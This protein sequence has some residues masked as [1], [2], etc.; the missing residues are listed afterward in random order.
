LKEGDRVLVIACGASAQLRVLRCAAKAGVRVLILGD[1]NA[2]PLKWSTSCDEFILSSKP[3]GDVNITDE[4]LPALADEIN[5]IAKMRDIRMVIPSDSRTTRILIRIEE[6]LKVPWFPIPS[7]QAFDTLNNKW[8]FFNLCERIGVTVPRTKLFDTTTDLIASFRDGGLWLPA[9]VKPTNMYGEIGVKKIS[10]NDAEQTLKSI[11]YQPI[12]FQEFINGEDVC[13]SL[14]CKDGAWS[15]SVQYKQVRKQFFYFHNK[16]LIA[17]AT[18]VVEETRFTG[19]INF[20][21][22]IDLDSGKIYVL[23]CNPRFWYTMDFAMIAGLNFIE[24][25]LRP[26]TVLHKDVT[27]I[28]VRRLEALARALVLPWTIQRHDL[29]ALFAAISDPVPSLIMTYRKFMEY[30]D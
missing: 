1:R 19:V 11:V 18:R 28:K 17:L 29:V 5:T 30:P 7:L 2:V 22:R 14:L 26:D 8:Q 16:D 4:A 21:A 24:T 27:G 10:G 20:D 6:L 23:E 12:L 13:I 9:I 3:I 25:Q 15:Y